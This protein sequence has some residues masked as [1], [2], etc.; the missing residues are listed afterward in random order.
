MNAAVL[1]KNKGK[2]VNMLES[3]VFLRFRRFHLLGRQKGAVVLCAALALL[4]ISC[5]GKKDQVTDREP[6][7]SDTLYTSKAAMNIYA[8]E[9]ERALTIIDS[10]LLLGNV[11][12]N[13]AQLMRAKIFSQSLEENQ[14]DSA[15][16]ILIGLLNSDYTEDKLMREEVFDLLLNIAYQRQQLE[17]QLHWGARKVEC[18]RDLGRETEALRTEVNIAF[19]LAQLGEEEKA[20]A[21]L[22]NIIAKLDGQRHIDKMDACIVALKR[23]IIILKQMER[24]EDA[25]PV[26]WHVIKILNGYREHYT[27][28]IDDSYRLAQTDEVTRRYCDFYTAQAHGSIANSYAML[29]KTDSARHYLALY[30]QSN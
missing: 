5:S 27:E 9:P 1:V 23:K 25:I 16:E 2:A 13:H 7:A 14:L 4:I 19:A 20:L 10:A 15:Q 11:E 12:F 18:C 30:E 8:Y 29:G 6:Q 22:N 3:C 17:L 24:W 21:K 26:A 28:Y